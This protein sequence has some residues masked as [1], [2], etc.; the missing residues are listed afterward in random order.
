MD[1]RLTDRSPGVFSFPTPERRVIST[2]RPHGRRPCANLAGWK[3]QSSPF[4]RSSR[5]D[6]G[7]RPRSIRWNESIF[8]PSECRFG[9]VSEP[10]SSV[11]HMAS[12]ELT[13]A[14]MRQTA[15][16]LRSEASDTKARLCG[17]GTGRTATRRFSVPRR[18]DRA[19]AREGA[20]RRDAARGHRRDD[21]PGRAPDQGGH[22]NGAATGSTNCSPESW[23]RACRRMAPP[24]PPRRR[25]VSEWSTGRRA[26][27]R[28][29]PASPWRHR[30]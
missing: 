20:R 14:A 6:R 13:I 22:R 23:S 27:R 17:R 5:T 24:G 19:R 2:F 28:V 30:A 11:V 15:E 7:L 21:P 26:T 1:P 12:A 3:P 18:R 8:P 4:G 29:R 10:I 16:V 9:P 25:G